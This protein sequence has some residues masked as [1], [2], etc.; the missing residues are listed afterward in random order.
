MKIIL[1]E[2]IQ[3]LGSVGDIVSVKP[4]YARNYLLPFS[5]AQLATSEAIAYFNERKEELA[6]RANDVLA[7]AKA[8]AE[9]LDG[10]SVNITSKEHDEGQL[11]GSVGTQEIADALQSTGFE[12][13]RKE[14]IL[15]DG[16]FRTIGEFP[17]TLKLHSEVTAA[18]TIAIVAETD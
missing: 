1:L 8:R 7:L 6:K 10:L 11:Y 9:K 2:K 15:D 5:K 16:A 4:G 12:V 17:V 3:N 14:I 13:E 18:I